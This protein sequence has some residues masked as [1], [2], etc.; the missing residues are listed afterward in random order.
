MIRQDTTTREIAKA[1]AIA[2]LSAAASSLIN[3]GI[4]EIKERVRRN[5]GLWIQQQD[6]DKGHE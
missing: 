4:D 6:G 5:R 1:V 3:W 2:A